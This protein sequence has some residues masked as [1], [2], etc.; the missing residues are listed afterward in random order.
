MPYTEV[1][2]R[3]LVP[4]IPEPGSLSLMILGTASCLLLRRRLISG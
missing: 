4:V 3:S 2:I 1:C